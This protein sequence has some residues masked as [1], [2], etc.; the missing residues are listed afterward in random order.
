MRSYLIWTFV[1]YRTSWGTTAREVCFADWRWP[2]PGKCPA[3]SA[4]SACTRRSGR[5]WNR[6]AGPGPTAACWPPR[7]PEPQVGCSCGRWRSRWTWSSLGF[8]WTTRCPRAA[9]PCACFTCTGTRAWSRC[10][11]AWRRRSSGASRRPP[12][13]FSST[14]TPK[15]CS[16][17]RTRV[18]WG[19]VEE[20][21]GKPRGTSRPSIGGDGFSDR[22]DRTHRT[23]NAH[24]KSV[25]NRYRK[26]NASNSTVSNSS[27]K[28]ESDIDTR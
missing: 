8:S 9:G 13:C 14:S 18:G 1:F 15:S 17:P 26:S 23:L 28:I 16:N 11:A 22:E 27:R 5:L 7:L 19:D 4:F 21:H 2:W 6:L 12:F 20:R 10:T 3:T 24:S 25:W